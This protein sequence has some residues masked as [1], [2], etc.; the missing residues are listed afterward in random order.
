MP[1]LFCIHP[2]TKWCIPI[3]E[4]ADNKNAN[5]VSKIGDSKDETTAK[6][7]KPDHLIHEDK[8]IAAVQHQ[9]H[10]TGHIA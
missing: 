9:H 4:E 6:G 2:P 1:S 10:V 5:T 8:H 7:V 3:N